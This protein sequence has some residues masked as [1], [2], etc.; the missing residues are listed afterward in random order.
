MSDDFMTKDIGDT[1]PEFK[2]ERFGSANG[3]HFFV[4]SVN[5]EFIGTLLKKMVASPGSEWAEE[6]WFIAYVAGRSMH[7]YVPV[8]SQQ[9][10]AEM[11]WQSHEG[12]IEIPEL[13][14]QYDPLVAPPDDP[15]HYESIRQKAAALVDLVVEND[16]VEVA[17]TVNEFEEAVNALTSAGFCVENQADSMT[18]SWPAE[19]MNVLHS[20]VTRVKQILES[21]LPSKYVGHVARQNRTASM[22]V[23][24]I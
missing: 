7:T 5:G 12:Q 3:S 10:G 14:H 21:A 13:P 6:K 4:V 18:V 15:D 22:V 24:K 17:Q 1:Y 19:N 9:Q 2:I 23:T 16:D 20:G 8:E 11:L